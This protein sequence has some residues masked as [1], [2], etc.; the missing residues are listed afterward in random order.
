VAE[1]VFYAVTHSPAGASGMVPAFFLDLL[2]EVLIKRITIESLA[3]T[4]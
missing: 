3:I 2:E 1:T 4:N